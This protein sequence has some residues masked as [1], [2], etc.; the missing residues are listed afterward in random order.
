MPFMVSN[1]SMCIAQVH[2]PG[3]PLA[4]ASPA[5]QN[6]LHRIPAFSEVLPKVPSGQ[7]GLASQFEKRICMVQVHLPGLSLA[8]APLAAPIMPHRAASPAMVLLPWTATRCPALP[9]RRC[10]AHLRTGLHA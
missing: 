10:P 1:L 3:L 7:P 9:A 6:M 2:L 4:E 8:G 5:A